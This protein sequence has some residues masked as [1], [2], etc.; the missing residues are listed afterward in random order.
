[1]ALVTDYVFQD[2]YAVCYSIFWVASLITLGSIVLLW[3]GLKRYLEA[4]ETLAAWGDRQEQ[5]AAPAV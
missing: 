5:K 3:K 4:R 2:D 1:M